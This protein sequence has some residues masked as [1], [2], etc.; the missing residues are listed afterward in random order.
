MMHAQDWFI[1]NYVLYGYEICHGRLQGS[2]NLIKLMAPQ[3][4]QLT[5][6]S[7]GN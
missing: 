1:K 7:A 6:P 4:L 3:R 2:L 5:L